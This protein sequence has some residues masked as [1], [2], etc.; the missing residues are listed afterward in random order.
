MAKFR[1][2]RSDRHKPGNERHEKEVDRYCRAFVPVP[3]IAAVGCRECLPSAQSATELARDRPEHSGNDGSVEEGLSR[4][5]QGCLPQ[6]DAVNGNTGVRP[7]MGQ[8]AMSWTRICDQRDR[9]WA[10]TQ[11]VQG[12]KR[13]RWLGEHNPAHRLRRLHRVKAGFAWRLPAGSARYAA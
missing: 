7:L 10:R 4:H 8:F 12:W 5:P 3:A 6:R 9:A 13:Y 1:V 11:N 2:L